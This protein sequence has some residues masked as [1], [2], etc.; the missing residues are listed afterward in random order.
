MIRAVVLL[1]LIDVVGPGLANQDCVV[2]VG[3]G[4]ELFQD[5]VIFGEIAVVFVDH[6]PIAKFVLPFKEWVVA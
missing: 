6:L 2:L 1:Q 3:D 4:P 5:L